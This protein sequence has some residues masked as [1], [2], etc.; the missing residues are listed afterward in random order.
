MRVLR[1][2]VVLLFSILCGPAIASGLDN[3]PAFAKEDPLAPVAQEIR[4]KL[5]PVSLADWQKLRKSA[6]EAK[7]AERYQNA[8]RLYK[9]AEVQLKLIA[10]NADGDLSLTEDDLFGLELSLT[11]TFATLGQYRPAI[12]R[13]TAL[14]D[15]PSDSDNTSNATFSICALNQLA[16]LNTTL[17]LIKE[18]DEYLNQASGIAEKAKLVDANTVK[19]KLLNANKELLASN[20]SASK[21]IFEKII[22]LATDLGNA[23]EKLK[24]DALNGLARAELGLGKFSQAVQN[25][26][27]AFAIRKN[28]F[29]EN[30]L[31]S[32]DSMMTL[33]LI[34][35]ATEPIE[36]RELRL[37]A[38]SIQLKIL[39]SP[40]HQKVGETMLAL[41][42]TRAQPYSIAE[43]ACEAA[44]STVDGTIGENSPFFAEY[45]TKLSKALIREGKVKPGL[46]ICQL[47][48]TLK[49]K[50]Y[51]A[52]SIAVADS[53]DDLAVLR[54][55]DAL[56]RS[57]AVGKYENIR[58]PEASAT[59]STAISI[60]DEQLGIGSLSSAHYLITL[61]L[62]E[63][64]AGNNADA[65]KHL[66][67]SMTI[68]EATYGTDCAIVQR[69]EN[70][71]LD[72]LTAQTKKSESRVLA[73]KLLSRQL[74][75][76]GVFDNNVLELLRTAEKNNLSDSPEDTKTTA[77]D[78]APAPAEPLPK[79]P[80]LNEA[81]K[82]LKEGRSGILPADKVPLPLPPFEEQT[83]GE[84]NLY[85]KVAQL[86][87][88]EDSRLLGTMELLKQFYD[89]DHSLSTQQERISN[90][91]AVLEKVE[92]ENGRDSPYITKEVIALAKT[93]SDFHLYSESSALFKR[94]IEITEVGLGPNHPALLE[95]LT[96]YSAMLKASGNEKEAMEQS[97]RIDAIRA[98]QSQPSNK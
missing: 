98:Q 10:E 20:Y 70:R 88:E 55:M 18:A 52:Q 76:T 46:E 3:E 49:T 56:G 81:T 73:A 4:K 58:S 25:H 92:K 50:L 31:E 96:G 97:K 36:A 84:L 42:N 67:K 11:E 87:P 71:L 24:A 43:H 79:T 2:W 91:K 82:A 28:R 85:F 16:E 45:L 14:L 1:L 63:Q 77:S 53:L 23:G 40:G 57:I 72:V 17:G 12:K 29:G 39:E 80:L 7:K 64:V 78:H 15:K 32:A 74:R 27:K 59:I 30:S 13:L 48:V 35:E 22:L 34:K 60:A 94:A 26:E 33:A 75:L 51:G 38:L 47:A 54:M 9:E 83:L 6:D 95:I 5:Q 62:I 41:I 37:A 61:G 69:T 21:K 89:P 8:L 93:Y 44:R 86:M 68:M 90:R 66:K 19:T 65:E